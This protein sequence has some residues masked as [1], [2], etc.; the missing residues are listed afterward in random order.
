MCVCVCV[1]CVWLWWKELAIVCRSYSQL[2]CSLAV[3]IEHSTNAYR[4]CC[5][6]VSHLLSSSVSSILFLY[7]CSDLQC[8]LPSAGLGLV[9]SIF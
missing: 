9:C 3:S 1:V 5:C 8:F 2:K 7:L 4:F 6:S